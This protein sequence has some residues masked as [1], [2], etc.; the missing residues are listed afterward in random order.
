MQLLFDR[1]ELPAK[2]LHPAGKPTIAKML[3]KGWIETAGPEAYR[4]TSAGIDAMK[5]K[6]PHSN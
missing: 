5:T 2:Q 1:G 4:I 6:I 3:T